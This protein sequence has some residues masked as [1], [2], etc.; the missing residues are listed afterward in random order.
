[1]PDNSNKQEGTKV[2]KYGSEIKVQYLPPNVV[3][4]TYKVAEKEHSQVNLKRLNYS[5]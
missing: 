5:T 3:E 1:M 2:I 4:W